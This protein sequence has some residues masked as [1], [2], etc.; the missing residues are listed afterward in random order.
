M[1]MWHAAI[2]TVPRSNRAVCSQEALCRVS[3][4]VALPTDD[5]L[6]A[7]G[8][9]DA[10]AFLLTLLADSP[11]ETRLF[12][13]ERRGSLWTE[14]RQQPWRCI[15]HL[16][17]FIARIV[18]DNVAG[19]GVR[20]GEISEVEVR[21][22]AMQR[23][24][25]SSLVIG[26]SESF[27]EEKREWGSVGDAMRQARERVLNA[28]RSVDAFASLSD[29]MIH[30]LRDLMTLGPFNAGEVVFEQGDEGDTFYVLLS[31][32][33]QVVRTHESGEEEVLAILTD[34]AHFGERALLKN[35][36]RYATI[37]ALSK[38]RTMSITRQAFEAEFGALKDLMDA[39]KYGN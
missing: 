18:E 38:L 14:P 30:K 11:T 32:E 1:L 34:G 5:E 29:P 36:M 19:H 2:H 23:Q 35:D 16:L 7:M 13:Q 3:T 39:D 20:D 33:A 15:D 6:E 4:L 17:T 28:L 25:G 10:G 27:R 12:M 21:R 9:P 31:G 24:A 8:A 37:K 26:G 22:F